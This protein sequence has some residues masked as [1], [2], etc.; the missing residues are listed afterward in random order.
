MHKSNQS[1]KLR[2]GC[3]GFHST[4][5]GGQGFVVFLRFF[6]CCVS[7][8]TQW[9]VDPGVLG[10]EPGLDRE[11]LCCVCCSHS[12]TVPTCSDTF[13]GCILSLPADKSCLW[14]CWCWR[15]S[16]LC[17]SCC[18][19]AALPDHPAEGPKAQVCLPVSGCEVEL[20]WL[21]WLHSVHPQVQRCCLM[22]GK[23]HSP[24]G[25][26]HRN[27]LGQ[28]GSLLPKVLPKADPATLTD[29]FY[30]FLACPGPS[31]G[32]V[33]LCS[34]KQLSRVAQMIYD[35]ANTTLPFLTDAHCACTSRRI[36]LS[37]LVFSVH[38]F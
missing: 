7:F 28:Q 17:L 15:M 20:R 9:S 18:S 6:L 3:T 2:A 5:G 37:V 13:Y 19:S 8:L 31:W 24:V 23:L 14:W 22:A 34:T 36:N 12:R 21:C 35:G 11:L 26:S 38:Q 32:S 1:F 25:G 16:P 29:E 30:G 27:P 4:D 10:L 33:P